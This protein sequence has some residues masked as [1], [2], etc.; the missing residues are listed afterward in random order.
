MK[1]QIYAK[2]SGDPKGMYKVEK[3]KKR[4]GATAPLFAGMSC[5]RAATLAGQHIQ[6]AC[7]ALCIVEH[8]TAKCW[9]C[10]LHLC[11][12]LSPRKW[13]N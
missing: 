12:W 11:F 4:Q 10:L 9:Q 3:E 8:P 7:C 6:F 1:M 2:I 13:R 5:I